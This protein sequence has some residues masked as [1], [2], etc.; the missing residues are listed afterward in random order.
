MDEVGKRFSAGD[1]FVPEMLMAAKVM[2]E[3]L[4]IIKPVL[5]KN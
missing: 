3:G 4:E 5:R 1:I 2:K